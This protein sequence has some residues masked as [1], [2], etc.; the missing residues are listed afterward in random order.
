MFSKIRLDNFDNGKHRFN[1]WP[2]RN[3]NGIMWDVICM[4]THVH[5]TSKCLADTN[6]A[7]ETRAEKY[8]TTEAISLKEN[9]RQCPWLG[10]FLGLL[11]CL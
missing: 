10:L 1:L 2:K 9:M 6:M 7:M 4:T 3:T 11:L 8:I 5:D